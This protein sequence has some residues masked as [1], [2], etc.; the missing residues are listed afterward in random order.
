[1]ALAISST[2]AEYVSSR[3]ACQQELW[4]KQA[5]V[6]YNIKLND[7]PI[8]CDN[9]GAIYLRDT[10]SPPLPYQ[11][12]PSSPQPTTPKSTPPPL[13][14]TPPSAP[15]Q[16]LRSAPTIITDLEPLELIFHTPPTSSHPFMDN[17]DDLPL[18][19]SHPPPTL[20]FDSI[21]GIALQPP[22]PSFIP[23]QMDI[24]P[25]PHLSFSPNHLLDQLDQSM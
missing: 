1:M 23:N 2:E 12:P 16:P 5:L 24:E 25:P 4:M 10:T 9:K 11:A 21:E 20:T 15:S 6:D 7:I 19:T 14:S 17:L 22:R 3:L 8:L 13:V 18:R